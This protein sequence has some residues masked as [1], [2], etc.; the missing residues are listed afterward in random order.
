MAQVRLAIFLRLE[1]EPVVRFWAGVGDFTLPADAV[2]TAGGTYTGAGELLDIPPVQQLINGLADR[3]TFTLSGVPAHM[4]ALAEA[5][6]EAV[7]GARVN[8]GYV[9]LGEDLQPARA[10]RWVWEGEADAVPLSKV[11]GVR[12]IGLSVGTLQTDRTRG[13]LET[14]SPVNQ[15]RRSP[16]DKGCDFVSLYHQGSTQQWG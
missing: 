4:M 15:R 12:T 14:Y 10:T 5:D 13:S 6:A 1:T 7:R 9:K 3:V 2:E 8:L 16:T 11:A